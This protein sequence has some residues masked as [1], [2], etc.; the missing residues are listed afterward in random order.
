MQHGAIADQVSI[1]AKSRI[2]E[3]WATQDEPPHLRTIRDRLLNHEQRANQLLGLYQRIN[4]TFS[5][6]L[7]FWG[8]V[9]AIDLANHETVVVF[10]F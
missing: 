8:I 7:D 4:G 6:C 5:A 2:I 9:R 10:C 1:L 3:N